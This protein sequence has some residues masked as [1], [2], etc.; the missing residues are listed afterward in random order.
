MG[1][2]GKVAG[3]GLWPAAPERRWAGSLEF[4]CGSVCSCNWVRQCVQL[5]QGW[6]AM[7]VAVLRV[8]AAAASKCHYLVPSAST[9]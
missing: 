5:R 3:T 1:Q 6:A 8:V 4:G 2:G 7:A 9:A